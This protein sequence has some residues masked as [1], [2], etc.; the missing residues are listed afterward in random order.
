MKI[1]FFRTNSDAQG[2]NSTAGANGFALFTADMVT[3]L[4]AI[5]DAP[6]D[7]AD[8]KWIPDYATT[9]PTQI[10]SDKWGMYTEIGRVLYDGKTWKLYDPVAYLEPN[11]RCDSEGQR[12]RRW[13]PVKPAV[14]Y[15]LNNA[16]PPFLPPEFDYRMTL[17]AIVM[18]TELPL[19]IKAAVTGF[20]SGGML[21]RMAPMPRPY[22]QSP[23]VFSG[24]PDS[25]SYK[26]YVRGCRNYCSIVYTTAYT[27]S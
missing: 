3:E 26:N 10:W 2:S 14:K 13:P 12:F 5:P 18:D 15:D 17:Q 22:I 16:P 1:W 23:T 20:V 9:A 19:L 25:L 11:F 7:T 4:M 27:D 24:S 21:P 8:T 6:Y